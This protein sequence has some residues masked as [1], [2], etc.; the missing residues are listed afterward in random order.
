MVKK[1]ELGDKVKD[2]I[3]GFIGIAV[4][5]I[6]FING[7]IQYQVAPK[8]IKGGKFPE[9][10]YIDKG[11]LIVLVPKNKPKK[12]KKPKR[13]PPGGPSRPGKRMRGF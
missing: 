6:E 1:I 5:R 3:T 7:C 13:R 9:D 11:S 8:V 4:A 10:V 2:T 12:V